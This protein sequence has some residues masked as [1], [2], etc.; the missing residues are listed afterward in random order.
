MT[1]SCVDDATCKGT[2][3]KGARECTVG[4]TD[5]GVQSRYLGGY[6]SVKEARLTHEPQEVVDGAP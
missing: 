2:S 5:E 1:S 3:G 6:P 4:A